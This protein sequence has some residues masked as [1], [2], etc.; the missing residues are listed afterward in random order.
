[1]YFQ[2]EKLSDFNHE[3]TNTQRIYYYFKMFSGN[4]TVIMTSILYTHGSARDRAMKRLAKYF[5]I[6]IRK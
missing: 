5:N 4:K 3:A 1:M 2:P 6:E